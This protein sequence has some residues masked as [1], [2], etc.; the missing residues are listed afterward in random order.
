MTGRDARGGTGVD[1]AVS[2]VRRSGRVGYGRELGE[3]GFLE[4][5]SLKAGR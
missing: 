3:F 5:R 1:D 2:R 4:D